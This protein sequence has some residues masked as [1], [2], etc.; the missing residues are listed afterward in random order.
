[1]QSY[2]KFDK[3]LPS[4]P[5]KEVEVG[6]IRPILL[7]KHALGE[8][9]TEQWFAQGGGVIVVPWQFWHTE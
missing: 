4:T 8:P 6:H 1:M 2:G 9:G 7:G 5:K 3:T